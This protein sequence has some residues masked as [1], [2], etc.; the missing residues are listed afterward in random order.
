MKNLKIS[1]YQNLKIWKISKSQKY[2]NI[3]IWN[4]EKISKSRNPKQFCFLNSKFHF[5]FVLKNIFGQDFEDNLFWPLLNFQN[6]LLWYKRMFSLPWAMFV[7]LMP[8]MMGIVLFSLQD[9]ILQRWAFSAQKKL[10][11]CPAT[12]ISYP[13]YK[14]T[15][16]YHD[17]RWG[18]FGTCEMIVFLTFLLNYEK[19]QIEMKCK[20]T[21]R[22]FPFDR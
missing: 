17:D 10:I 16:F 13:D 14:L 22:T 1:K 4:F 7:E 9:R 2:K 6:A 19:Y 20:M 15:N 21:G 12:N 18:G 5:V 8:G 11:F 3:K